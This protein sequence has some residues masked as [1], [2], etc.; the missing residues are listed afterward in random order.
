MQFF[1]GK[2]SVYI[3]K[4]MYFANFHSHLRYAIL[5]WGGDGESKK[6]L[7]YKKKSYEINQQCRKRYTLQ[8]IV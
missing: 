1:Q 7:N 5:F 3:L 6:I 8:G 2:T 4:S